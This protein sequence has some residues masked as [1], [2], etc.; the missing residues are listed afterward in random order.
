MMN[1]L[2]IRASDEAIIERL[3]ICKSCEHIILERMQCKQC[4]CFMEYKT[5]L[6]FTS[7]PIDK[8]KKEE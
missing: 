7:C 8:W 4:G 2:N 6:R 1:M 3:N 5:L